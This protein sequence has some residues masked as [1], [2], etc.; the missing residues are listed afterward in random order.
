MSSHDVTA[1]P[2]WPAKMGWSGCVTSEVQS[3]IEDGP[4]AAVDVRARAASK[5]WPGPLTVRG[6]RV[7]RRHEG[8]RRKCYM[9][10]PRP[11]IRAREKASCVDA[12][13]EIATAFSP[14]LGVAPCRAWRAGKGI[15][16]GGRGEQFGSRRCLTRFMMRRVETRSLCRQRYHGVVG[17]RFSWGWKTSRGPAG[18]GQGSTL[19]MTQ[20]GHGLFAVDHRE[21]AVSVREAEHAMERRLG[22]SVDNIL[23]VQ[24]NLAGAYYAVGRFEEALSLRRAMP[25][26]VNVIWQFSNP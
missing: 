15:D 4:E 9:R 21:E 11:S 2:P 18:D 26:N 25:V 12:G 24:G 14:E 8:P 22:G 3:R 23:T 17:A 6:R 7:R 19:A 20:L 5:P 1:L 13:V 10:A 16:R